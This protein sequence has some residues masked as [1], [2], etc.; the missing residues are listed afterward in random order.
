M[1]GYTYTRS[2]PNKKIADKYVKK[3][4][5]EYGPAWET[6]LKDYILKCECCVSNLSKLMDCDG[7]T[8]GKYV[9]K[10]G[11]FKLLNSHMKTD[12]VMDKKRKYD[13]NLEE[14]YK[15]DIFPL[16]LKN[17][18]VNRSEIMWKMQKQYA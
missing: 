8:I 4:V 18:D 12:E 16:L 9:K 11:V 10:L 5:K 15:N 3:T 6:A 14:K 2:G 17:P 13:I 1:C 7:K